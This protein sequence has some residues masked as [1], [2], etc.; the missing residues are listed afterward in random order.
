MF[1]ELL[2]YNPSVDLH[3]AV[4]LRLEFPG[5]GQAITAVTISPFPLLRLSTGV[6]LQLLMMVSVGPP[7][8]PLPSAYMG[9]SG[10]PSPRLLCLRPP[11]PYI[12]RPAWVCYQQSTQPLG[13]AT[14]PQGHWGASGEIGVLDEPGRQGRMQEVL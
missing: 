4:T 11:C 9:G 1:V 12:C 13:A 3:V 14:L 5:A 8:H 10:D 2:Q 7:L 6:T